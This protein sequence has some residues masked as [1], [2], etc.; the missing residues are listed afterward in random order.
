MASVWRWQNQHNT[1]GGE[2]GKSGIRK[3]KRNIR[4]IISKM[5]KSKDVIYFSLVLG[6]VIFAVYLSLQYKY[7]AGPVLVL[8][9][10]LPLISAVMS[11]LDF[12]RLIP[13]LLFGAI[14]TGLLTIPA[15]IGGKLFGVSG[16]ILGGVAGDAVTDGIAGFFEGSIAEW[17]RKKGIQESR[18]AL[19]SGLGKTSGC[20][21][22]AGIVLSI[23]WLTGINI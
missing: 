3:R 4:R 8:L 15:L 21:F 11:G 17:L 9:A 2:A 16:A 6:I 13:D 14:D 1:R 18:T 19:S 7:P 10:L 12:K 23:A 5:K 20:L 22:G